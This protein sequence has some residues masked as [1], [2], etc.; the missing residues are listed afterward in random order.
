MK[1]DSLHV[2]K[3]VR[4]FLKNCSEQANIG[5]IILLTFPTICMFLPDFVNC[6]VVQEH[7]WKENEENCRTFL[8]THREI[9]FENDVFFE[10][11]WQTFA[12]DF[13]VSK[14]SLPH[15]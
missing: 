11:H 12:V 7:C 9:Y 8:L 5:L 15:G 2:L 3:N 6:I 1:I 10:I 4:D 14:S 13:S